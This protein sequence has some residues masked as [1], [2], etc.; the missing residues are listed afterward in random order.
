MHEADCERY[1]ALVEGTDVLFLTADAAGVVEFAN[2][3]AARFLGTA[4]AALRGRAMTELVDG[5]EQARL[6]LDLAALPDGAALCSGERTTRR[7]D[8]AVRMLM[9]QHQRRIDD[10]GRQYWQ[11]VAV[12]VTALHHTHS[13]LGELVYKDPLTGLPNRRLFEDRLTQAA[14]RYRRDGARFALH[15][16]DVDHFKQVNDSF[17]HPAGDELLCAVTEVLAS[18]LRE[19]DTLARL[20]GDE[21]AIL[22]P[23]VSSETS[24]EMLARKI[25]SRFEAPIAIDG[26]EI[27]VGVSI[28]IALATDADA[29]AGRLV[30]QADRA[31]YAVK[32][33]G[34][35]FYAFD[36]SALGAA[37]LSELEL[38]RALEHASG[39]GS[40]FLL[41]QP[42]YNLR[43]GAISAVE[44]LLR[45]RR[46]D[47]SIVGPER[48][49][50][51]AERHGLIQGIGAWVIEHALAQFA[52][53]RGA[54]IDVPRLCINLSVLQLHDDSLAERLVAALVRHGVPAH[55][56]E[57]EI[58]E[59]GISA[60]EATVLRGL[61]RLAAV[62]VSLSIDDFGTGFSSFASLR[63]F[64]FKRLKVAQEF[65]ERL[66]SRDERAILDASVSLARGL[67]MEAVVEGVESASALHA[68][69][70]MGVESVQGFLISGPESS[71]QMEHTLRNPERLRERMPARSA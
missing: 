23:N 26:H 43:R 57:L 32:G 59:H 65:A 69:E 52:A 40:L 53:W 66:G 64:A 13:R 11:L 41:W 6:R 25:V 28:G 54:G 60:H 16:I 9:W 15:L 3:A 67:G 50:A 71:P 24:A 61:E 12:D 51:I 39:D 20:G 58:A 10:G 35:G 63:R 47:G 48:T 42:E 2:G 21:F 45:W 1:R 17:G 5:D 33:S 70:D 4:P 30:E 8:G 62:G 56:V 37:A 22:Q 14:A 55:R 68:L 7:A 29:D 46:P 44:A 38:A 49:I 36:T 18:T 27:R 31:L 34:R 19:S